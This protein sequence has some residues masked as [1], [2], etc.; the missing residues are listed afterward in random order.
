M[1]GWI[2][3]LSFFGASVTR[4]D[5]QNVRRIRQT[6]ARPTSRHP[7]QARHQQ[8][9]PQ[10]QATRPGKAGCQPGRACADQ[11]RVIANHGGKAGGDCSKVASD[12]GRGGQKAD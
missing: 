2:L 9:G 10:A 3:T 8:A 5:H 7:Q 11:R 4:L 6:Q 12:A 1:T